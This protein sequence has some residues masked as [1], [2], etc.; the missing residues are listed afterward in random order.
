MPPVRRHR[1][2]DQLPAVIHPGPDR[3]ALDLCRDLAAQTD[4]EAVILFASRATGGWD[5]QSD[6]DMIIVHPAGDDDDDR[7]KTL[8]RA[9]V[10]LKERHYPGYRDRESPH[11]GVRDGQMHKTPVE[12]H[13]GRRTLNHVVARAAREGRIFTRDPRHADAF[14]HDGDLSN[15]WELVTVERLRRSARVHDGIQAQRAHFPWYAQGDPPE[16]RHPSNVHTSQGRDAHML[17]WNS[18]VALLS[19]LGVIYPRDSV[20][21]TATAIVRHDSGWSHEFRSDLERIDQYSGCGCEVVVTDPID[22]VATMWLDL[23]AD[24]IALWKRIR[25]LSGYDLFPMQPPSGRRP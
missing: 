12:Y 14:R 19:I 9:L 8:G 13:A 20:S 16:R 22:D 1:I 24:R 6:L 3:A 5:R 21:E 15:E 23:E 17:L 18:G 10:N 25:E 2:G 7:R 4:A 11:H